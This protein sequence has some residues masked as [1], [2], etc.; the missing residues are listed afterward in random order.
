MEITGR[1]QLE[2]THCYAGSSPMG[3]HGTMTPDG[4][5]GVLDQAAEL[6]VTTVQL[7]GGE[8]TLHPA[9]PELV[10]HALA[11]DVQVE[12]FTNLVHI[13]DELWHVFSRPGVSLATSYYSDDPDRHAA[14]TGRPSLARTRANISKALRSGIP[15]RAGLIDLADNQRVNEAAAELVNLGVPEIGRDR[16]RHVGRGGRGQPGTV[17]QLCGQC[18][19]GSA[20]VAADG[21]VW[22]CVFSRWLPI[23]NV[24]ESSLAAALTSEK[25][26]HV[27]NELRAAF[28]DRPATMCVPT[29]CDPQCGPSCSPACRP[30]GNCRPVGACA[31]DYG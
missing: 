3:T 27:G 13:S 16:L 31:P 1:C 6:G 28:A 15:L 7:I 29:M 2:C 23:G 19:R 9:L 17:G 21:T 5:R 20:A 10:H 12:V 11:H 4:W 26:A 25:A 18:G 30:A 14:I 22:P 8:P 24:R